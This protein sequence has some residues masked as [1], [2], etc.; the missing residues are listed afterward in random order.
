[1]DIFGKA[2]R[3]STMSDVAPTSKSRRVRR[4]FTD[5]YRAGA[6]RLVIDEH[7]SIAQVARNST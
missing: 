7:R 5:E 4:R 1:V 3:M 2:D 6:V